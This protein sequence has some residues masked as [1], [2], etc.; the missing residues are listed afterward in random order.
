MKCAVCSA[1]ILLGA[2]EIFY[3][4]LFGGAMI[5]ALY[6]PMVKELNLQHD[7]LIILLKYLDVFK[8]NWNIVAFF[9]LINVIVGVLLLKSNLTNS[10]KWQK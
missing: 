8:T 2:I 10:L 9:G 3:G 5:K 1:L 4:L 6:S 7:Q